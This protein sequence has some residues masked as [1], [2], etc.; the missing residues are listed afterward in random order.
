MGIRSLLRKVFGRDRVTSAGPTESAGS[1]GPGASASPEEEAAAGSAATATAAV[2]PAQAERVAPAEAVEAVEA[3]APKVTVPAPSPEP[4]VASEASAS[5][6]AADLVA[7]AFD[8]PAVSVP[9]QGARSDEGAEARGT[10]GTSPEPGTTEPVATAEADEVTEPEP[11]PVAT[12]EATPGE[13]ARSVDAPEGGAHPFRPAEHLPTTVEDPE[14]TAE[15]TAPEPTMVEDPEPETAP[16][17][18]AEVTAPEPATVEDPAAEASAEVTA[19]DPDPVAATEPEPTAKVTVEV[20]ATEPEAEAAPAPDPV[21]AT[22]PEP[23]PTAEVTAPDPEPTAKVTAEVTAPDPEPTAK[24][25]AEVTSPD[26]DPVAAT[27]PEPAA[28]VAA[29]VSLG[30]VK[31]RAPGLVAAYKAAGSGLKK[32]ESVGVRACVYLVLDRSG[33]MRPYYKDGSAQGLAEQALAL[34]AHLDEDAAVHVV[35]FSTEIDGTGTLT[36]DAYEGRVDAL[37]SGLGRMGRTN[38]H[39]AVE[40]VVAHHEKADTGRPALVV[41]QTDGAPDQIRAAKQALAD[42]ADKPL[43]WQFV[44]FG[45]PDAKGFDFLRKLDVPNAA[46]FAAGAD[47]REL[48]DA[49]VFDGLLRGVAGL[50]RP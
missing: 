13:P 39:R 29:A 33:S 23:E 36:L 10:G 31:S 18:T 7:A 3:P 41:F 42:A 43:F 17:A 27:E 37:H 35:F 4:E 8:A 25:T 45:E 38:Y 16:V 40:E 50:A 21:T 28:K 9:A 11:A 22:E 49:E 47:P 46:Y 32:R 44:S 15:V 24:V 6:S 12:A 14:P 19:P 1:A 20:A 30:R 34:A 48:T 5:A 26:P 2:V